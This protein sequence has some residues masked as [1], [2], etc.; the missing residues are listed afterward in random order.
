MKAEIMAIV[1]PAAVTVVGALV[2]WG[3]AELTRYIRMRTKSEAAERAMQQITE[4]A[5]NVVQEL[6][7]SARARSADRKLTAE[8]GRQLKDEAVRRIKRQL[9]DAVEAAARGGVNDL[10]S[11]LGGKV[12]EAVTVQKRMTGRI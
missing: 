9:P 8:E 2:S 1:V 6:E 4:L 12:E 7:V 10:R 5:N 11:F 3:L